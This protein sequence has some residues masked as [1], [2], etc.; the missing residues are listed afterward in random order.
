MKLPSIRSITTLYNLDRPFARITHFTGIVLVFTVSLWWFS[1]QMKTMVIA[2]EPGIDTQ[3]LTWASA[4][5]FG[6]VMLG[7]FLLLRRYHWINKVVSHGITIK[8]LIKKIDVRTTR[9][10]PEKHAPWTPRLLH[11]YHA[12]VVYDCCGVSRQ[13]RLKLPSLSD[14]TMITEG[15]EVDLI[16]LESASSKPLLRTIFQNWMHTYV[17]VRRSTQ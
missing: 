4:V 10:P 1:R 9:L 8:G 16:V 15:A 3:V 6:T 5:G 17:A 14:G 11:S 13:T 12:V 2:E 7:L